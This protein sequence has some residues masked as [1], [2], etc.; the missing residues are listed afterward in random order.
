MATTGKAS[1]VLLKANA[2]IGTNDFL[3]DVIGLGGP[4][5]GLGILIM[6]SDVLLDNGNQFGNAPKDAALQSI[7][8]DAAEEALDHVEP[9]SGR[10]R[11][12]DMETRMLFQPLLGLGMLV[13]RVVVAH[14]MQRLIPGRLA[15]DL[16]Q[17]FK[18]F[19]VAMTRCAAGDD[20]A[21][22]RA[23]GGKQ[24]RGTVT[25]VVMGHRLRP[26]LLQRQARLGVVKCL[27]LALLVAAQHQRMLRWRHSLRTTRTKNFRRGAMSGFNVTA[28]AL[29]GMQC[30]EWA[31]A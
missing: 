5:E 12:M 26:S 2:A 29:P 28:T 9:G 20:R 15:V 22:Q 16:A 10:W 25:L 11:E 1:F 19:D 21:V 31:D 13:R 14:Q 30:R 6:H 24:G 17:E 7:S 8:R 18:P 4:N 23:Q 27:H 3:Q